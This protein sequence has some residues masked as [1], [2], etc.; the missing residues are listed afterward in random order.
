MEALVKKGERIKEKMKTKERLQKYIITKP[1]LHFTASISLKMYYVK[2]KHT[3]KKRVVRSC[4]LKGWKKY[5]TN[6]RVNKNILFLWED[7]FLRLS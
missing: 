4:N 1:K 2:G 5:H 6:P 3:L 7:L